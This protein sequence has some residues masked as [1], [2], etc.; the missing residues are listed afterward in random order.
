MRVDCNNLNACKKFKKNVSNLFHIFSYV[1]Y[2]N[3]ICVCCLQSIQY[4]NVLFSNIFRETKNVLRRCDII[5]LKCITQE[6]NTAIS[7]KTA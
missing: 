2:Y 5:T 4:E 7:I 1:Q 3:I 6:L